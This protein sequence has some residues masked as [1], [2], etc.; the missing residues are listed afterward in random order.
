MAGGFSYRIA[1]SPGWVGA[2]VGDIRYGSETRSVPLSLTLPDVLV[3]VN[4]NNS[5]VYT[6]GLVRIL[7]STGPM[8]PY[9][10]ELVGVGYIATRTSVAARNLTSTNFDDWMLNMGGGAG[11]FIEL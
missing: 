4:I 2:E 6:H 10:E 11:A 3:N 5:I 7:P 1:E 8:R 9:V